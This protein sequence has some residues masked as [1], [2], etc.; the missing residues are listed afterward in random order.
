MERVAIT[1]LLGLL[2]LAALAGVFVYRWIMG[3]RRAQAM[4]AERAEE[5][6]GKI[7]RGRRRLHLVT[8]DADVG[9]R[10]D[11]ATTVPIALEARRHNLHH[12]RRDPL[13]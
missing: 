8:G 7:L 6:G 3:Q 12:H 10:E 13:P 5:G 9:P 1:A 2:V 4:D 11:V